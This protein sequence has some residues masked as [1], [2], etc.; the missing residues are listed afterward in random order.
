VKQQISKTLANQLI[1]LPLSD[2][3]I[4]AR[5]LKILG[6]WHYRKGQLVPKLLS[7]EENKIKGTLNINSWDRYYEKVRIKILILLF[8]VVILTGIIVV[9]SLF[10]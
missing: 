5:R 8:A 3:K 6:Y 4:I 7:C 2:L 9:L 10:L 1:D